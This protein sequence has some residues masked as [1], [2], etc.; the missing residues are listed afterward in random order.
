[1]K[2]RYTADGA[3][4]AASKDLASVKTFAEE[5]K[6]AEIPVLPTTADVPPPAKDIDVPV[7][8]TSNTEKAPFSWSDK[9]MD[10]VVAIVAFVLIAVIR[11]IYKKIM[12]KWSGEPSDVET[13][14]RGRYSIDIRNQ[15][16]PLPTGSAQ[17]KTKKKDKKSFADLMRGLFRWRI[18]AGNE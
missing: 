18:S 10:L 13:R 3:M 1:M 9:G 11:E 15:I 6:A 2:Y 14:D 7:A 17:E 5:L 12:T 16:P 8:S 4:A